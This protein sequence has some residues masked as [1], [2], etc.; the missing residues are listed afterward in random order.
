MWRLSAKIFDVLGWPGVWRASD[1]LCKPQLRSENYFSD[2]PFG[3]NLCAA[4]HDFTPKEAYRVER[5]PTSR[6]E[7]HGPFFTS[8]LPPHVSNHDL[9]NNQI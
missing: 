1:L 7:D 9:H 4:N 3:N 2:L 5:K 6:S 8:L